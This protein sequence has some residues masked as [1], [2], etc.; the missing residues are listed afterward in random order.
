[1]YAVDDHRLALID[2][3]ESIGLPG[4][5]RVSLAVEPVGGGVRET[6]FAYVKASELAKPVHT[7]YLSD[8]RDRRFVHPDKRP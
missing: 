3:I 7:G 6:A 5:F 4:N 8:Y 2:R 1:L